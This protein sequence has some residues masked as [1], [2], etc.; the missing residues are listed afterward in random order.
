VISKKEG[1]KERRGRRST[2]TKC[3]SRSLFVMNEARR[4]GKRERRKPRQ[5][6][7]YP[8]RGEKRGST[9]YFTF[10][11]RAGN[12]RKPLVF[13]K[14]G[15]GKEERARVQPAVQKGKRTIRLKAVKRREEF[16]YV[17]AGQG[18]GE[19]KPTAG[20]EEASSQRKKNREGRNRV[21]YVIRRRG[22]RRRYLSSSKRTGPRSLRQKKEQLFLRRA[23]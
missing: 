9:V 20:E 16:V 18:R 23:P 12:A 6:H 19:E 1:E 10:S 21:L 14:K 11:S 13:E 7:D 17:R 15:G 5:Y 4:E 22:G 8:K 2:P 3:P